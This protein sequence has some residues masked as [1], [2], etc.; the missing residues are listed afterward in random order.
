[1]FTY[2]TVGGDVAFPVRWDTEPVINLERVSDQLSG[3]MATFREGLNSFNSFY[4]FLSF[5]KV[6]EYCMARNKQDARARKPRLDMT[7]PVS[8]GSILGIHK[9][10]ASRL[11]DYSGKTF[12]EV[13]G[14]FESL[15]RHAAAHLIPDKFKLNPGDL[16]E[17]RKFDAKMPVIKYMAQEMLRARYEWDSK[18][19]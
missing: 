14:E 9:D 19:T 1:M 3:A 12:D 13:R 10:D 8:P 18:G 7:I 15:F 17:M 11:S 6:V 4:R 5:F 2:T 16:A